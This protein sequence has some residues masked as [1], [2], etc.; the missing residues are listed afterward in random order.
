MYS[1]CGSGVTTGIRYMP[2]DG[3]AATSSGV[4]SESCCDCR[5]GDMLLFELLS[6]R[7]KAR[8]PRL[9]E[10]EDSLINGSGTGRDEV[11]SVLDRPLIGG[12]T[13]ALTVAEE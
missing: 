6:L 11:V 13:A 5:S 8:R 4:V 2:G 10:K 1:G 9:A 12:R 3:G 7:E